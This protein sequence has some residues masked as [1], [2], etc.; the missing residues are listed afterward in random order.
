MNPDSNPHTSLQR[1]SSRSF[2][3]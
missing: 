2:M 3:I 1:Q